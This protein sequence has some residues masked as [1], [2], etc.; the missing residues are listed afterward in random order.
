MGLSAGMRGRGKPCGTFSVYGGGTCAV[1]MATPTTADRRIT[2]PA[3][4]F[5]AAAYF[6]R[7]TTSQLWTIRID[8]APRLS[9]G[10]TT[11]SGP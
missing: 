6:R 2:V 4:H 9:C 3:K 5:T 11:L 8:R 7:R 10:A 1:S